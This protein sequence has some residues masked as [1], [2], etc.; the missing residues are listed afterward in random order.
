MVDDPY[1]E[2]VRNGSVKLDMVN[3]VAV[4]LELKLH[5]QR[6]ESRLINTMKSCCGSTVDRRLLVY[7]NATVLTI[8]LL[9]FSIY[10][11]VADT[12]LCK[13]TNMYHG[14]ITFMLGFWMGGAVM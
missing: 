14:F 12:P 4:A 6:A 1:D 9:I 11:I 13:D 10:G 2:S 5:E 7:C 8:V 3:P